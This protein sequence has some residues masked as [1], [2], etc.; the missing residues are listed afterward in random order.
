MGELHEIGVI[1]TQRI[2]VGAGNGGGTVL[3]S[4]KGVSKVGVCPHEE[5]AFLQV[6]NVTPVTGV[7]S[8]LERRRVAVVK[9]QSKEESQL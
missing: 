3:I 9:F 8:P 5:L 7:A 1:I 4:R 2:V 6:N